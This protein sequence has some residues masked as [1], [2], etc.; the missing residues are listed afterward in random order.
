MKR[1]LS[2]LLCSLLLLSTFQF[3]P[4][5]AE[6]YNKGFKIYPFDPYIAQGLAEMTPNGGYKFTANGGADLT[7]VMA[8]TN[9]T[10]FDYEANSYLHLVAPKSNMVFKIQVDF[11]NT[12][13]GYFLP[14]TV[15]YTSAETVDEEIISIDLKEALEKE[16][17]WNPDGNMLFICVYAQHKGDADSFT[18]FDSIRLGPKEISLDD[19]FIEPVKIDM[20]EDNTVNNLTLE[21][22]AD[23]SFL[24]KKEDFSASAFCLKSGIQY[25]PDTPYLY[26]NFAGIPLNNW[27]YIYIYDKESEVMGMFPKVIRVR[28]EMGDSGVWV[29]VDLRNVS[30]TFKD[31]SGDL[32]V[33]IVFETP[34]GASQTPL[35]IGGVYLGSEK[36][37]ERTSEFPDVS[38]PAETEESKAESVE[39]QESTVSETVSADASMSQSSDNSESPNNDNYTIWY[40]V[41]AVILIGAVTIFSINRRKRLK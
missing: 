9:M 15:I 23:D 17:K 36:F 34:E 7:Y 41:G 11:H 12:L 25:S 20:L 21:K 4:V 5:S 16:E 32:G 38:V 24:M 28:P 10:N 29:R 13:D 40:I 35:K 22:K 19:T 8:A 27:P 39:Q 33:K 18:V 1:T 3:I 2:L 30:D 6:S 14:Q 37:D 26:I 31:T